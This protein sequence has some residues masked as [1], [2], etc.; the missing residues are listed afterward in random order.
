VTLP[1]A[2]G[3]VWLVVSGKFLKQIGASGEVLKSVDLGTDKFLNITPDARTAFVQRAGTEQGYQ[4]MNA[5]L[6]GIE[7]ASGKPLWTVEKCEVAESR[8]SDDGKMLVCAERE[9]MGR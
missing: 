1:V 7:L 9:N 6:V 3:S 8:V 5:S 4:R 2:D